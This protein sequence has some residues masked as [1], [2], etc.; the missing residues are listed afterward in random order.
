[1]LTKYICFWKFIK[2]VSKI[3]GVSNSPKHVWQVYL[4][5]VTLD[6]SLTFTSAKFITEVA[7]SGC[8]AEFICSKVYFWPWH[9]ALKLSK[10]DGFDWREGAGW[11]WWQSNEKLGGTATWGQPFKDA[12]FSQRI[13]T[14]ALNLEPQR[15]IFD[16]CTWL[17]AHITKQHCFHWTKAERERGG[18]GWIQS[19]EI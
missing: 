2:C 5:T 14:D 16:L 10:Q 13:Y 11:D 1:M 7:D 15:S 3:W 8:N 17:L 9:L 4:L 12:L 19:S 18:E 6:H